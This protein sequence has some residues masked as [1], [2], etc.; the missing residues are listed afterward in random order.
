MID[1]FVV[2]SGVA[3]MAFLAIGQAILNRR[4]ND[5]QNRIQD[6]LAEYRAE[7][8]AFEEKYGEGGE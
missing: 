2:W 6:A 7:I 1:V 3:V 5:L 8:R 4:N